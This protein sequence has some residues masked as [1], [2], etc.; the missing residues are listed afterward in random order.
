MKNKTEMEHMN[1]IECPAGNYEGKRYV[2]I[3]TDKKCTFLK[4][5][6]MCP[7]R[8]YIHSMNRASRANHM[9]EDMT[10]V[11]NGRNTCGSIYC[12]IVG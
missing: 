11:K 12:R 9:G 4:N 5:M 7:D 6:D 10:E 3:Y 1:I 8:R 2:C